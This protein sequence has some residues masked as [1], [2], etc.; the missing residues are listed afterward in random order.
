[1]RRTYTGI[2]IG[3]ALAAGMLLLFSFLP[4]LP[5]WWIPSIVTIAIAIATVDRGEDF[6]VMMWWVAGAIG[7]ILVWL[8]YFATV[9]FVAYL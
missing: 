5:Y 4:V 7:V 8:A 6:E 9:A 2:L 1:M 3:V